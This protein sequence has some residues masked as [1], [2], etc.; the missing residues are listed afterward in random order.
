MSFLS[1]DEEDPEKRNPKLRFRKFLREEFGNDWGL[2]FERGPV[3]WATDVDLHSR[4]KLDQLWFRELKTN[5]SEPEVLTEFIMN[6]MGPTVGLFTNAAEGLRRINQGEVYR[7]MEMF[8]PAGIRSFAAAYRE[9]EEGVRTLKGDTVVKKEDLTAANIATTGLGFKPTKVAAT[10]ED[11]AQAKSELQKMQQARDE[12]FRLFKN[13]TTGWTPSKQ[14]AA[15]RA[16]KEYNTKNKLDPIIDSDLIIE[17]MEREA[18]ARGTAVQ[19]VR[20][21]EKLRPA[22]ER[23]M[24]KSLYT[25]N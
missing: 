19:G 23:L 22:L 11:A 17:S 7:G 21:S 6:M 14:D 8:L 24:P 16:L 4:T 15:L 3:S 10:L 25:K 2:I 20:T 5:K 18:E 1:E 12:V 9:S 13:L